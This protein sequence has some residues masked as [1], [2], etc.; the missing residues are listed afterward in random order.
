VTLPRVRQSEAGT[1]A[2]VLPGDTLTV[3]GDMKRGEMTFECA[4]ASAVRA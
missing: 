1:R 3:D 2:A 4:A